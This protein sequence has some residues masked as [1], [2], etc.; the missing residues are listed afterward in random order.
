MQAPADAEHRNTRG[1]VSQ[2]KNPLSRSI[3]TAVGIRNNDGASVTQRPRQA[4]PARKIPRTH[5][6]SAAAPRPRGNPA[7]SSSVRFS[8]S[9]QPRA[10]RISAT[11][12]RRP[13]RRE[14]YRTRAPR[15]P[16]R[17]AATVDRMSCR[18]AVFITTSEHLVRRGSRRICPIRCRAYAAERRRV[19]VAEP[20]QIRGVR[21][22]HSSKS[23]SLHCFF[24]HTGTKP[25]APRLQR[26]A[27]PRG[28]RPVC[29]MARASAEADGPFASATLPPRRQRRLAG[30]KRLTGTQISQH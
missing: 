21:L 22:P 12:S 19:G 9:L 2:S 20:Q 5:P 25:F 6:A 15:E 1:G 8:A 17:T 29:S 7:S 26:P 13:H 14:E 10:A 24:A 3:V 23:S 4:R 16:A 18:E 27:Q 28:G 11:A 30:R